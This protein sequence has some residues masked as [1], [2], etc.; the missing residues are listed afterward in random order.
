MNISVLLARSKL[1]SA[2]GAIGQ[3][4]SSVVNEPVVSVTKRIVNG[5]NVH[6]AERRQTS[7]IRWNVLEYNSRRTDTLRLFV[8]SPCSANRFDWPMQETSWPTS[9]CAANFSKIAVPHLVHNFP[10]P[11]IYL[12]AFLC[13]HFFPTREDNSFSSWDHVWAVYPAFSGDHELRT[14]C[15]RWWRGPSRVHC[16]IQQVKDPPHWLV[17]AVF[18]R[19]AR[20]FSRQGI[21]AIRVLALEER[22]RNLGVPCSAPCS[23]IELSDWKRSGL[24]EGTLI[25]PLRNFVLQPQKYSLRLYPDLSVKQVR[26]PCAR[27]SRY[28]IGWKHSPGVPSAPRIRDHDPS[29]RERDLGKPSLPPI[30]SGV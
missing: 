25:L 6:S 16:L 2:V 10:Q 26:Q 1:H 12:L 19:R 13:F 30:P 20:E 24:F 4:E 22:L 29:V 15:G 18:L 28:S 5:R 3:L 27:A 8:N 21:I 17:D 9:F 14:S 7:S 23:V 11:N